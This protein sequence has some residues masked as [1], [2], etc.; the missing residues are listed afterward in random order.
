VKI[1]VVP[2]GRV[3]GPLADAVAEYEQRAARYFSFE[4]QEV[5][6][7][8]A[9]GQATVERVRAEEGKRLLA[10]VQPGQE[11]IALHPAGRSWSSER[12]A[13]H[14]S[15]LALHARAGAAFLIGGA[16]GLSDEV[17]GA[18]HH[19]L[20]LSGFTLPHEVARLVLCEQIYR[21]GTILRGEPYHKTR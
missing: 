9:R 7:E 5:R 21:A 13:H 17:L 20:S 1:L 4:V 2:V 15:E 16:Y 8:P 18:S 12:L 6:E 3:R 19:L 10:R 11:I 14:L